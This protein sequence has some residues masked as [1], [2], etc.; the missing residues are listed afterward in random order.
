MLCQIYIFNN[1]VKENKD[2][3]KKVKKYDIV[4]NIGANVG[5]LGLLMIKKVIVKYIMG[6]NQI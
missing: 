4:I 2:I 6:L 3:L 5:A 1:F